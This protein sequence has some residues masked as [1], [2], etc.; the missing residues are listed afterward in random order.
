[1]AT[2]NRD[3][4]Q[5][6]KPE[7]RIA[8]TT[9]C[10]RNHDGLCDTFASRSSLCQLEADDKLLF[11]T[12]ACSGLRSLTALTA[13]AVLIGGL[14]LKTPIM[15]LVLIVLAIPVATFL[16]GIRVFLTGFLVH[17]VNP[18][19]GDGFMHYTEGWMVFVVAFVILGGM[20]WTLTNL[21]RMWRRR[22]VG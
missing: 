4:S 7:R 14:W 18:A 8:Q 9:R 2:T 3:A 22:R 15:R 5:T 13:L 11:V 20:A 6:H 17:F 16:N 21:E 19:L 12:E 10:H 1:M